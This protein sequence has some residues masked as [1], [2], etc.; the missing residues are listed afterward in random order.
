MIM[1][2]T[3]SIYG[4]D[5]HAYDFLL[6]AKQLPEKIEYWDK[7]DLHEEDNGFYLVFTEDNNVGSLPFSFGRFLIA[8]KELLLQREL[9]TPETFK[10]LSIVVKQE[11]LAAKNELNLAFFYILKPSL[12]QLLGEAGIRVFV[13]REG[14][15]D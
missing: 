13:M 11:E 14:V 6:A 3:F 7:E 15:M 2:V 12:M 8:N 5:F 1:V 4:P 10:D 9:Y